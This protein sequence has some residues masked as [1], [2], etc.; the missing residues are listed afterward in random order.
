MRKRGKL[1]YV[2]SVVAFIVGAT[3][4]VG[5]ATTFRRLGARVRAFMEPPTP[6]QMQQAT[7]A[8]QEQAV[9]DS[10]TRADTSLRHE[11]HPAS[12]RSM[13]MIVGI[14]LGGTLVLLLGSARW[15]SKRE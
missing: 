2:L 7:A 15:A 4:A 10:L 9:I 1:I 8:A 13:L 5:G 12:S 6:A 11:A 14:A 3:Y